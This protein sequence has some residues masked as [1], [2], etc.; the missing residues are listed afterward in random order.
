MQISNVPHVIVVKN[1]KVVYVHN[2]YVEGA[3]EDLFEKIK[4]L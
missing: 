3:E 4:S 1:Q 2:G